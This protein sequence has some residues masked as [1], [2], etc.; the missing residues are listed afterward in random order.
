M[1]QKFPA[2]RC[3]QQ[4]KSGAK[5]FCYDHVALCVAA[6]MADIFAQFKTAKFKINQ[7]SLSSS[8]GRTIE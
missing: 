4:P 1:G 5:V 2:A 8:S 7:S 6:A 3:S